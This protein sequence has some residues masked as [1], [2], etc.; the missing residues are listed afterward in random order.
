[1]VAISKFYLHTNDNEVISFFLSHN[2]N[3][4]LNLNDGDLPT[5][6]NTIHILYYDVIY[7]K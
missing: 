1:M 7:S 6:Y 4:T 3:F 5:I 2:Y